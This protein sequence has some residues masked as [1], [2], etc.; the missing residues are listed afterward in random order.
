MLVW[1]ILVILNFLIPKVVFSE[2]ENRYLAKIPK[3][4]FEKLV[5]GQYQEEWD[6]YINDHFIFRN[7][8][9][10]IKSEQEKI[11]GKTEY[12]GV[13]FGKDGYLFEKF[14]YS[15]TEKNNIENDV[16]IINN[17]VTNLGINN[18]GDVPVY[19]ILVPNSIYI[20][21]ELLP[22]NL[23]VANQHNI[24]EKFY[25]D[26]N[27]KINKIDVTK[28]ME[29]NKSNYIFF[30][31]D[32]H[33]TSNGAYLVYSEFMKKKGEKVNSL[34]SYEP[35]IISDD[36]LGTLDSKAQRFNQEKDY[37]VIYKNDKNTNIIEA[38]Y[39]NQTTK[40]I[41][42]REYLETKDKYS[43]FL[44]GNNAKVVIKTKVQNG[45][46][47]LLVKDSYAHIMA[48]FL[49]NDYEEIHLIDSRYYRDSISSYVKKNNISEVLFLYNVS[50][51]CTDV[52][53]R[54]LK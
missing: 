42:N 36:F 19:F 53:I 51:L 39:D 7:S 49:C 4:S 1:V 41:Y 38:K 31:T 50:N 40:S 24:I 3:F 17:F 30:K 16:K 8:W 47:I 15:D 2:Q 21:S 9:I 10:K 12:N 18:I 25:Q 34:E 27:D 48:Q 13:I 33:M 11:L 43:F 46:K 5:N 28:I 20:N 6:N 44:N 45:K 26:L 23:E 35:E 37:I 52:G 32:H 29:D 54:N 22:D 14:E